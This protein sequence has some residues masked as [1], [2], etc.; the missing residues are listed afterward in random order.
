MSRRPPQKLEARIRE[1]ARQHPGWTPSQLAI[2]LQGEQL[3]VT[4]EDVRRVLARPTP[5]VGDAAET[6]EQ[7]T[8]PRYTAPR[9]A[10]TRSSLPVGLLFG[11]LLAVFYV[12]IQAISPTLGGG[13]AR[14]AT[15]LGTGL[16]MVLTGAVAS[17][18][19]ASGASAGALAGLTY[20]LILTGLA[21]LLYSTFRPQ[22]EAVLGQTLPSAPLGG[23]LSTLAFGVAVLMLFFGLMGAVLGWLGARLFGR[24]RS[25]QAFS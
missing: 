20:V 11:I 19:Y 6:E 17:R 7:P 22:L 2:F 9:E 5:P 12:G 8:A 23:G 14:L 16:L 21:F 18:Q 4:S 24:K 3:K 25:R 1:L 10:R 15:L 13:V